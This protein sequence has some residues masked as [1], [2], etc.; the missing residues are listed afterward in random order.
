MEKVLDRRAIERVREIV[1]MGAGII[2]AIS[3]FV[4]IRE[5]EGMVI[6]PFSTA[7]GLGQHSASDEK[8]GQFG[9]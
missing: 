1:F 3:V 2:R 9:A 6:E 7:T 8:G 5:E 4:S